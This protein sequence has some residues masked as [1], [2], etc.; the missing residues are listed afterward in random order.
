MAVRSPWLTVVACY[1]AFTDSIASSFVHDFYL[2]LLLFWKE[3]FS[4]EVE[5]KSSTA[6]VFICFLFNTLQLQLY[7]LGEDFNLEKGKR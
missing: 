6:G 4:L 3:K 5:L 7:V 1:L 2:N